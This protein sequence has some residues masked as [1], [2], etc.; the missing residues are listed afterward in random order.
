MSR[1]SSIIPFILRVG[2]FAMLPAISALTPLIAIPVITSQFGAEGWVAVALGISIGTAAAVLVELGWGL[3]GSIRIARA[4]P[5]ARPRILALA[6]ITKSLMSLITL[7]PIVGVSLFLQSE[8]STV[9]ILIACAYMLTGTSSA[10]YFI[11]LGSPGKI[12]DC[13][14]LPR[15]SLV[16][17]SC[18]GMQFWDWPIESY[19]IALILAALLSAVAVLRVERIVAS[20]FLSHSLRRVLFAFR[21]QGQ[22]LFARSASAIYIALPVVIVGFV[23]PGS[24]L[25]FSAAERLI[26]MSLTVLQSVPNSLQAYVG[27]AQ[28]LGDRRD[29]VFRSVSVNVAVGILAA[30][31]FA[32]L[33]NVLSMVLFSDLIDFSSW[34]IVFGSVII[35]LTCASRSVGSLGLVAYNDVR[36]ISRSAVLGACVG[37]IG[38][39]LG[40]RYYGPSGALGAMALAEFAVLA[41]QAVALVQRTQARSRIFLRLPE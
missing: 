6:M 14:V 33:S 38:L 12:L 3:N 11:G 28:G 32:A 37:V 22:A 41:Y 4:S 5:V 13:E 34:A 30:F 39:L 35:F 10:W 27:G 8:G 25:V 24:V 29:R 21:R 26:R 19:C 1:L 17:I 9:T 31:T 36:S 23:S 40:A 7:G 18:A 15:L 20:D 2:A 16:L